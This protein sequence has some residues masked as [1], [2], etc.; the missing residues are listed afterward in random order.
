M[1]ITY[2]SSE[3]SNLDTFYCFRI[4]NIF[5]YLDCDST[6]IMLVIYYCSIL[7]KSLVWV[8]IIREWMRSAIWKNACDRNQKKKSQINVEFLHTPRDRIYFVADFLI[9]YWSQEEYDLD[10]A[11]LNRMNFAYGIPTA[12]PLYLVEE[13]MEVERVFVVK[14]LNKSSERPKNTKFNFSRSSCRSWHQQKSL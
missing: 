2:K 9:I 5:K 12:P 1:N 10:P 13:A 4:Y 8:L 7:Y 3:N 14:V 6:Y 11:T